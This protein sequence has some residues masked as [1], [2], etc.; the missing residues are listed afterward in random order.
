M[1]L[2]FDIEANGLLD[3]V[4][5]IHCIEAYDVDTDV[6]YS[7]GPNAIHNGCELLA[8]ADTLIGHNIIC[9]DLPALKKVMGFE[10][11]ATIRDTLV[12]ARLIHSNL[13][14]TDGTLV[15]TGRLDK[16]LYGSNNLKA[17]GQRIGERKQ[18][19]DGGFETWNQEMQDYCAQDVR[20][21]VQ[22]WRYL[23]VDQYS[24]QA[25]ELENDI[26]RVCFHMEQCGWTFDRDKAVD[27][28]SKLAARRDELHAQLVAKF[29]TWQEEAGVLIPKKDNKTRGYKAGVPVQKYKTVEFN[30]N[31]RRHIEKKL[32]ELGWKPELFTDGGAAKLDESVLEKIDIPEAKLLV[33]HFMV[34]KRLS[35]IG[36]GDEGWLK[37]LDANNR[38]HGRYNTMGTVT[39]R[40]SHYSPNLGQVPANKKPFGKDCREL[41]TVPKGWVMVGA[42]MQGLELRCLAHYMGFFDD[43]A[44]ADLVINGDVH[45]ENQ[46]AAG[47]PT[48]DNAKTFIYAF[49]YG[50]GDAKI[51]KIV[52]GTAKTGAKLKF[53][54]MQKFPALKRLRD[55][56]EQAS[57]KGYLKGLDARHI[58]IRSAHAGLNSL[59]QGCGAI[60]CKRWVVDAFNEVSTKY[61]PGYDGD[62]VFCGWIHD[63]VQVACRADIADD[64][65]KIIVKCAQNAGE[66]YGFSVR[67]DS[68]YIIG[69]NW[70]ETH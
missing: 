3:T 60:L 43:G 8:E 4:S 11:K 30:P 39:G 41:F 47:L 21:L 24:D 10:P 68:E 48:R 15:Q 36:D 51:G 14:D 1:R 16:E 59:L 57:T 65:G 31:S 67:L 52:K 27:L 2:A 22:L 18:E 63:E 69:A 12:V 28:Y 13:R 50:A 44:Y 26:A 54:F 9:Y 17:W 62:F 58:P 6:A 33:E 29:G 55:M 25:V 38:I 42:D 32:R 61:K 34:V 20:T 49:L 7:F 45:T 53:D 46:K 66:R 64:I 23:K 70:S 5:K 56:V 37:A 19:Y 35:Q 40:A